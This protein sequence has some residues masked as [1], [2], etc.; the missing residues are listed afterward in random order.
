MFKNELRPYEI[1]LWTLQDSFISVLKPYG[2]YH[3]GQIETPKCQIKNDGTQELNFSIPMYYQKDGILIE[4]PFWYNVVNGT[5]IVNLRKLKV[6]FNKGEKEEEIFEFVINNVSETHKEGQLY[7][8]VSAEG[9]AFQEL[10]KIGYKISLSSQ[11]FLDEY[12]EWAEGEQTLPEPKNNII[13]WCDKIFQNSNWTYEIQMDWTAYDGIVSKMDNETREQKGLRRTDMIY[14][15]EYIASWSYDKSQKVLIP[16]RLEPFK[17]KLRLV[18]LEKSNIYNLTQDVAQAFGVYCKYKYD[19]DINYHII[20]R[21]CIFYNNFLTE[22]EGKID[23]IYPYGASSIERNIDSA[24]VVTKM[25]VTSIED[26]L[27]PS[28]LVSIIDASANKMREDYILNFDY[29]YS[30]GTITQEQYD[31][32]SDYERS[33][34]LI[35][36]ELEPLGLQIANL[37]ED[38]VK[39]EAQQVFAREAQIQDKEQM[40]QAKAIQ[41]SLLGES[42]FLVRN[43][44]NPIRITLYKE[45]ET[46]TTYSAKIVQEGIDTTSQNTYLL[47]QYNQ[48]ASSSSPGIKKEI[49]AKGLRLFYYQHDPNDPTKDKALVPYEDVHYNENGEII[50]IK[51]SADNGTNPPA[52]YQGIYPNSVKMEFTNGNLTKLT[53]LKLKEDSISKTYFLTC[54]YSPSLHYQNIYDTY[55]AKLLEHEE[56][57]KKATEQIESIKEQIEKINEKQK[58]LIESKQKL[59]ADFEKMMGP[60][61]REGSWQAENYSNYD[62]KYEKDI[63]VGAFDSSSNIN[64]IWDSEPFEDEQLLYYL[65]AG[66][67]NNKTYYF[68]VDLSNCLENIKEHLEKLSFIYSK[69]NPNGEEDLGPYQMTIGAEASFAFLEGGKPILLLLDKTFDKNL[70]ENFLLGVIT[71]EVTEQGVVEKIEELVKIESLIENLQEQKQVFPRLKADSLLLKTSEDELIIKY[72]E[73]LLRNYYDYYILIRKDNYYITIKDKIMLLDANI[74]KTFNVSYSMSNAA[75]ALY[76]DALEVSKTNSMP[77]V[78]YSV[79]VS[80]LNKKLI[81]TLYRDLNRI[82]TINDSELKFENVEG[83]ISEIDLNL[84]QP[85]DDSLVVQNYKTKFEDLFSTIVASTEQMKVNSFAYNNAASSFGPGGSLKPTVLQNSINKTDLTYAF[86]GGSL[87]ID[88]INGIWSR[89]DSGVVAMKGGGIFCA[90]QTDSNGNWLWNTGI[91]PSGINA[92]LI[93][94]GQ[95]DTNLIKIYAGED[96]RL[97]LNSEGLFAYQTNGLGEADL[98]RYIV[99]NSDGLFSTIIDEKGNKINLVEV[100][101]DGFKINK[102]DGTT[103][104][105]ADEKGNL[106]LSGK[107]TATT[108][109]IGN[110]LINEKGLY[111]S[112]GTAGLMPNSEQEMEGLSGEKIFWVEGSSA[113]RGAKKEFVVTSDG[114][115]YCNDIIVK[116]KISSDSFIGNTTAG[117]IDNQLRTISLMVLDGTTF[118]FDNSNYDGNIRISPSE[119]KFRIYTNALSD[120]EL[121]KDINSETYED[122]S[123]FYSLDGIKWIEILPKADGSYENLIWKPDYLTF[124]LKSDIM[125]SGLE[126]PFSEPHSELYFKVEKLGWEKKSELMGETQLESHTY[127]T[128]IQLIS[129]KKNLNK[130]VSLVDP[131]IHTFLQDE[132]GETNYDNIT[133]SVELKGFNPNLDE[134]KTEIESSFWLLNNQDPELRTQIGVS[135]EKEGLI[136]SLTSSEDKKIIT[137]S[138]TIPSEKVSDEGLVLTYQINNV[139]RSASCFKKEAG[140]DGINIIIRSS[141]G[142]TLVQG[143]T[144]TEL[145]VEIYYGA[146]LVNYDNSGAEFFYVW[147]KNNSP[148]KTINVDNENTLSISD[149]D[150]FKQKKIYVSA[151]DF[152]LKAIYSCEVFTSE[153]EAIQEYEKGDTSLDSKPVLDQAILDVLK[154]L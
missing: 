39:Q 68:A 64:F 12:N 150:F 72:Q 25:F 57:E 96:L 94:T 114:T 79:G 29:L 26:E 106:T 34:Y 127:S 132:K 128:E 56:Q 103:V 73:E 52:V 27:S 30:I 110:W 136:F 92:S 20:G 71:T 91:M 16:S 60:A 14:E 89:S 95:L 28:G 76:L 49:Y 5:L 145:F 113:T 117:E 22:N 138:L 88:E 24:D 47:T 66:N 118:S 123:F 41:D 18:D 99:H 121:K 59:I 44:E 154:L 4:N 62:A 147:K 3:K 11:D 2:I 7:C 6:I 74:Q 112:N 153:E 69:K 33:M 134:D 21:R 142:E 144:Q 143:D 9:L 109:A 37:Q 116:G 111:T 152:N 42:G 23:I 129:E 102:P 80:A 78:S 148:L 130:H 93:T 67:L 77:Q 126:K 120:E 131:P 45:Q 124:V 75:L 122:Y 46:D 83:Y 10:G 38:L 133:F 105:Y 8:E 51:D 70:Y 139:T 63:T 17:E 135:T 151:K 58:E 149:T 115:L 48:G 107:I 90:T 140:L 104:F 19:Y 53:G 97:Q 65:D 108:G 81:K 100:S 31:S 36:I 125:Y 32:I 84:D 50:T 40:E 1:S 146:Q 101:W 141:S 35:N 13:Y 119:L 86:Q 15:D 137:A 98:N 87:T 43:K 61:L 54:T 82:V 55:L 85:W